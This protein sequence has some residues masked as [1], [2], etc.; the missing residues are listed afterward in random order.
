V[1]ICV[2]CASGGGPWRA[3]NANLRFEG[4]EIVCTTEDDLMACDPAPWCSQTPTTAAM[5]SN[6]GGMYLFVRGILRNPVKISA[7]SNSSCGDRKFIFW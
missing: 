5:R 4:R 7:A 3:P 1:V 2:H 6:E